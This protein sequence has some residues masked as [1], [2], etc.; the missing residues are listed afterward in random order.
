MWAAIVGELWFT[1]Y[2]E[3]NRCGH[4]V[5]RSASCCMR[6]AAGGLSSPS[7]ETVFEY[8][9]LRSR[10]CLLKLKLNC[11]QRPPSRR[12]ACR[13]PLS[14]DGSSRWIRPL[15]LHLT[16]C[17]YTSMFARTPTRAL[18][19]AQRMPG[20]IARI[21]L[22]LLESVQLVACQSGAG[23]CVGHWQTRTAG[24]ARPAGR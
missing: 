3:P 15:P 10:K 22:R 14:L 2:E 6:P 13:M 19:R 23:W 20:P 11:T 8:A 9:L 4:A 16:K 24:A 17:P 7:R 5:L 21:S 18:S 1:T 12:P